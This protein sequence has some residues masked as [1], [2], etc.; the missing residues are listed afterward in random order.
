MENMV[1]I[2][3]LAPILIFTHLFIANIQLISSKNYFYGVYVKNLQLDEGEKKRIDK[4]YKKKINYTFLVLLI[5]PVVLYKFSN[6]N[7][8]ILISISLI[9][10]SVLSFY[11]LKDSFQEAKV[12]KSQVLIKEPEGE[13]SLKKSGKISVD[14]EFMKGKLKLKRKFKILFGICLG[15][16][17]ISFL[18]TALNY[19]NLPDMIPTHYGASGKPDAFGPKNFVNA[20]L[21]NIIDLALVIIFSCTGIATVSYRVQLDTTD[22][23]NNRK[24]ALKYL[25][26]I[27]YSF[28]IMTL[29]IQIGTTLIPIYSVN[30]WNISNYSFLIITIAPIFISVYLIYSYIM[31][32]TTKSKV[33][34]LYTPESD[35]EKWIYGFIYY[36]K[37]DPSFM[38]DKR[39]G[40]GW[41][42]NMAHKTS[43]L[44]MVI[45][46]FITLFSLI[47]P[48]FS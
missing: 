37:E 21:I 15:L 12:L 22:L 27:G 31:L 28:W 17:I 26:R 6:V 25:N 16:S 18:Y 44:I 7:E 48:L 23:E 46:I 20:F 9:M 42:F 34:D 35:D 8:G 40:A 10:Y 36:N 39:M 43:K 4:S 11:Y 19:N 3:I 47:T 14:T 24:K 30:G 29:T 1:G 2:M 5:L 13:I 33:K 38:V 41:T 32:S 45:T